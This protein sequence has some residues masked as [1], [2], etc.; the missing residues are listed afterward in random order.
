MIVD[1][2]V[3]RKESIYKIYRQD[4]QDFQDLQIYDKTL[5]I[6]KSYLTRVI[7]EEII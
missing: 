7:C 2:Q 1:R 4:E 5:L 6:P 3:F